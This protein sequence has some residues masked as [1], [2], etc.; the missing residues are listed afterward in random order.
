MIE[1]GGISMADN[2]CTPCPNGTFAPNSGQE[3]CGPC[4]PNTY[5]QKGAS[6]NIF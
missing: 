1:I 5:S 4:P 3:Q 6:S 2:Y